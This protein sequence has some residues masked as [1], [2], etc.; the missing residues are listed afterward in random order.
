[1]YSDQVDRNAQL[2]YRLM[3][4]GLACAVLHIGAHPDDED[5]GL[6]AYLARK[7]GGRAVY[8]SATRG[9]GGQNRIGPYKEEALGVYRTWESLAARSV[10]GGECLFGPFYDF[11]YSKNGEEALAKWGRRAVIREVVRAIRLIQPHIIVARWT[12]K[13]R[14]VHGHHQAIGQA[15]LAAFEAAGDPD[16]FPELRAQGLAAW[17]PLK[18]YH[19]MGGDWNPGEE[20][21]FGRLDPALERD[22][23]LR[24]NTGEF[25]PIRG[26]TYQEQAWMAF[27][28]YQTQGIGI[29]PAPGDCFYYY[30]LYKSLV[31][32]PDKE[33]S[34]FDGLDPSLT[35]LADYPAT[36]SPSLSEKLLEIKAQA[37]EAL[38][39]FRADDPMAASTPLLEGLSALRETR[40]N[41]A[42]EGLNSEARQAL[43]WYLAR[44]IVDFEEVAAR[45]LGIELECL[46]ERSRIIPGQRFRMSARL[47]NHRGVQI[48]H[49]KF[50]PC[51]PEGWETRSLEAGGADEGELSEQPATAFDVKAPETTNLTCPYWLVKPREGYVYHWPAGESC[52]RPFGAAQVQVECEVA[53]GP[54]RIVLRKAVV[55]REAFPGGCR[56][57]SLAVIP[58][59]SLHPETTQEF[60]QAQKTKRQAVRSTR[61]LEKLL[62][63]L[64]ESFADQHLEL[65]VV[66]RN[67]S[68]RAVE[69]DLELEVPTGWKVAPERVQ[70]SL[71]E[72]GGAQTVRFTVTVPANTPEGHYPLRYKVRYGQRD[73]AVVLT[74]VRM[75]APGLAALT[76]G[77]CCLKEEFIIA[78][79][80]VMVHLIAVQFAPGLRYAYIQGAKE[81]LLETL[82]SLG[83]AFHLIT[84][85]EMGYLDLSNFDA[86]VVGP[87]AYLLREELRKNAA[88]FLEYV[89]QGGT[90]IVQ[91]Q[92]YG[93][94]NQGFTPYP[95]RYSQPHDRV[96]HEDA[97]VNIL[98]SDHLLFGLP[99][100]IS[101][102][103]FE[104]WIH[105]RGLYFFGEWSKRYNTLLSCS[106]PGEEPHEGGLLECQYGRGAF[107]Y[108]GY[109]F[110]RQLPAAVPGAFRLFANI[111]ALPAARIM[112]RI[113]FIRQIPLFSTLTDEQLNAVVQI[114]SERWE[115]NGVT[116][117]RQGEVG[118]ELYIVYR[119]EL[120]IIT[121]SNGQEQ[122]IS[123]AQAGDC[124]GELA[125][126]GNVTHTASLR[127]RG[128]VHLLVLEDTHFQALVRQ[129]PD[130]AIQ[131]MKFLA[132]RQAGFG[133]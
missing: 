96:T 39:R 102:A 121:E 114:M 20:G 1:M 129:Q 67:N 76:D 30:S 82:K 50:T 113:E 80:R 73:Y 104:G 103:D 9:E 29:T 77:S 37:D 47:W 93:Y 72:A 100:A 95:F 44:K 94:Q 125:L 81:E 10:D 117:C 98:D 91:Y 87:N 127:A 16:Q 133:G 42:K 71:T 22:G 131:M 118:H 33:S 132:S 66:A 56:E 85:A 6:L 61:E 38:R 48:D 14:D 24:I 69:G 107:L 108:T 23:V 34:F 109:S 78:P 86:V 35:G 46:G 63:F 12:G 36:G 11:G 57:L 119:G 90:L 105:D 99:N 58:P 110:F 55:H 40:A 65:Q 75:G 126:M 116:I 68:D 64:E 31:P 2:V 70:L 53:I 51:L 26:R 13:P 17:Q 123:Q 8:W 106:D 92:G 32:V 79:S 54:H 101:A 7:F 27:N 84:D 112:E 122:I 59:I 25:D 115:E 83:V 128:D 74:P 15:T 130:V 3:G 97:A 28:K 88:R 62:V 21:T 52:H 49:A 41:L 89:K 124:L 45:C 111:L 43:D 5:T 19:S 120:E 60:L 18:F 4:L